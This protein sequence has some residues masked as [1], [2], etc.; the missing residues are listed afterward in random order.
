MNLLT[1]ADV[2]VKD[3]LFATLDATT[4]V[5]D[6]DINVKALITD[7]VGF[8]QKLPH[9]LVASFKS[10][11]SDIRSSELIITI[12]PLSNNFFKL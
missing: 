8:I 2:Y 3:E 11:L 4:R 1:N 7:T 12:N 6:L 9:E 5:L 10:T